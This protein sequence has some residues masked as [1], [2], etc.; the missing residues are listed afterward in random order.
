[1]SDIYNWLNKNNLHRINE[2]ALKLL[3]KV[4]VKI[5]HEKIRDLLYQAGAKVNNAKQIVH[6]PR[7]VVEKTAAMTRGSDAVAM[8]QKRSAMEEKIHSGELQ[9]GIG[10]LAFFYYD[11]ER[12]QRRP[13][14]KEDSV[15][16]IRLGDAMDGITHVNPP[17]I[18]SQG[19]PKIE[20]IESCVACIQNTHPEKLGGK[21]EAVE[22]TCVK[23]LAEIGGVTTG[24]DYDA[25]FISECNFFNSPL[26]LSWR[27]GECIL[28]KTKYGTKC[29]IGSEPLSGGTSPV[30]P[31]SSIVI[32]A[33]EILTGW[34]VVKTLNP[35]IPVGAITC[36]GSI[37]MRTGRGCFS[38]PEAIIQDIGLYHLFDK[39]YKSK[40]YLV[41]PYYDA[42]IP[43][44]QSVFHHLLKRLIF[45]TAKVDIREFYNGIL[46]AGSTFSPVQMILDMEINECLHRIE[47]GFNTDEESLALDVIQQVGVGT[48]RSYLGTDHTLKYFREVQWFPKLLD[49]TGFE[50]GAKEIEK[51]NQILENADIRW[52]EAL[53]KWNPPEIDKD[54]L[55]DIQSIV[56]KARKELAP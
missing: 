23:Y 7:K 8:T 20:P 26:L 40:I 22:P 2:A 10:G 21:V 12:K 56:D 50:N 6:I 45:S 13:A 46:E 41:Y 47:K 35:G 48:G 38:S 5:E 51:E 42:K 44:L 43:G 9:Q 34:T 24:K 31:A 27:S 49:R 54:K 52:R 15:N 14:T 29:L 33:A 28:E 32:A 3:E 36:S 4:G 19:N 25:R 37:D 53:K 17:L 18:N 1:M 16:M 11:W 30:T 55:K 39:I